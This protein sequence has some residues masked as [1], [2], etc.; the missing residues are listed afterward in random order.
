MTIGL[1]GRKCGM[2]RVHTDDGVA[3]PV[4]VIEVL[5][6]RV[7]QLK[8]LENDGY[9]AV[10]I[11]VGERKRSRLSK[12][13]AGHFAKAGVEPGFKLH[14]F[15]VEDQ[16]AI[17]GITIG[18]ELKLDRFTVGQYVDVSGRTKGKGFAGAIKRHHFRSQDASHGNSRSHRAPGSIGQ[19]QSPGKVFKGKHMAGH[20]GDKVRTILSQKIVRIDLERNLVL[21]RGAVPGA[22]MG[23]VIIRP[24]VKKSA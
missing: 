6:N 17:D 9:V 2:T 13:E 7:T 18:S 5:P 12:P 11:T 21:V 15:C 4:T 24:A 8:T 16:K 19:R 22:A 3:I 10:Q 14:E 23:Y 1:L 20:L